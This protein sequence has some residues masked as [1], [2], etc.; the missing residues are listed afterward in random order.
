MFVYF[1][2]DAYNTVQPPQTG[3]SLFRA[4]QTAQNIS[5]SDDEQEFYQANLE[6]SDVESEDNENSRSLR[7]C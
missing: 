1:W 5:S 4:I 7:K 6:E 2:H 3:K